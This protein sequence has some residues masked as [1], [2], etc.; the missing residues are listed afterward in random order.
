MNKSAPI[1]LYK[2]R[3]FNKYLFPIL[4]GKI[5]FPNRKN[6]NDPEDLKI[7]I[8]NDITVECCKKYL[9]KQ[10]K[11]KLWPKNKIKINEDRLISGGLLTEDAKS[12]CLSS[13]CQEYLDTLGILSLSEQSNSPKMWKDYADDY[14]GVCIEFEIPRHNKNLFEISYVKKRKDLSLSDLMLSVDPEI[15]IKKILTEKTEAWG[16][17]KEWRGFIKKGNSEYNNIGSIKKVTVGKRIK[18][19]DQK[20][21]I[22]ALKTNRIKYEFSIP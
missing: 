3:P 21:L 12:M 17:E 15:D 6:L 10:A 13:K 16:E 4:N 20:E 11:L 7:N 22:C 2:Y 1:F 19:K 5:W 18:E 9:S 8:I 14:N